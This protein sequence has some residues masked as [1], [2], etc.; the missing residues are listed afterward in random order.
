MNPETEAW[1]GK[2]VQYRVGVFW[3]NGLGPVSGFGFP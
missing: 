2:F 3:N 1:T